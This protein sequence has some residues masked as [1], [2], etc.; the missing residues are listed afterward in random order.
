MIST[1]AVVWIV[2]NLL[3]SCC[4]LLLLGTYCIVKTLPQRK[5]PFLINMVLTS[6]LATIP[7]LMLCVFYFKF[8][9]HYLTK[10]VFEKAIHWS[11]RTDKYTMDLHPPIS[12]YGQHCANVRSDRSGYTCHIDPPCAGL[13]LLW[14]LSSS[15]YVRQFVHE[16]GTNN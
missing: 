11:A 2:M 13:V 1:I 16:F 8:G 6:Y 15:R 12:L 3:G 10:M 5:N 14:L 4:L 9:R 7:P